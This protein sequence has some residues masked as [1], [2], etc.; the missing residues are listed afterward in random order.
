MSIGYLIPSTSQ[1]DVPDAP[2]WRL[3]PAQYRQMIL[4]GILTEDDPVEL[5]EG[6]L[7]QKMS[8]NPPRR[9]VKR[10][11]LDAL[12]RMVLDGWYVEEQ[13]PIALDTSA[14]EPDVFIARGESEDYRDRDPE[15]AD[16][17]LV[18]EIAESSLARDR[19]MKKRIYARAGVPTYWIVNLVDKVI[20]EYSDPSG[21]TETPDYRVRRD[22]RLD[23]EIALVLDGIEV[24]RLFVREVLD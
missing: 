22:L 10:R 11:L 6:W 20:E 17:A 1:A 12:A 9:L 14:P 13:E 4:N 23:D 3:T 15:A 16:L 21:P 7:V 8:K 2:I 19:G 18:V 5:L 24:G